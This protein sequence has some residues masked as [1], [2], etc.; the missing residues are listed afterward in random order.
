[1]RMRSVFMAIMRARDSA[2]ARAQR[3]TDRIPDAGARGR[4]RPLARMRN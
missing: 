2:S 3:S 4:P 1:M